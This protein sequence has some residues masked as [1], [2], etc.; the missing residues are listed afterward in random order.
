MVDSSTTP[1]TTR[2]APAVAFSGELWI[3]HDDFRADPPPKYFRLSPGREVRLRGAFFITATDFVTD[4][5]GNVV[6][7]RAT[8]DPDTK[9]G[10]SPDGR[11]VKSTMHWVSAAARPRRDG[12]AV[13]PAVHGRESR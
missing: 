7:V 3:E 8:Y 6:E 13:R 9:G 1:R 10:S 12:R 11:K 5:A 4:D 2:T